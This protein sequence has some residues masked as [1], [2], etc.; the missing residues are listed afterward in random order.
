ME[1]IV[2]KKEI[3]FQILSQAKQTQLGK[4][5]C[6][7]LPIKTY[8]RMERNKLKLKHILIHLSSFHVQFHSCIPDSSTSRLR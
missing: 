4:K 2:K 6:I 5:E 1:K 3:M 8:S 7:L